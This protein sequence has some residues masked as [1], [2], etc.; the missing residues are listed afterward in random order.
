LA[1]INYLTGDATAPVMRPAVICH[2]CNDKGD[3][4]KGFVL[5][6]SRK[7][8]E[9]EKE[10]R[11]WWLKWHRGLPLPSTEMGFGLGRTQFVRV[12]D[13][14]MVANMVAQHGIGVKKG[15]IPLR[16]TALRECLTDLYG[17]VSQMPK[18]YTVHMPRI[19]CGLAGGDWDEVVGILEDV[20]TVDTY[21]YDYKEGS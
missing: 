20:I 19:G 14:I 6:L 13:D 12:E 7:W 18:A 8:K 1:N 2:V 11:L 10:Y 5:A 3:W 15:V 9:P 21:V 4:G 17:S 16:Y